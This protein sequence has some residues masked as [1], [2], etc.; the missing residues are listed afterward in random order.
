MPP[1]PPCPD[2][3]SGPYFSLAGNL[4]IDLEI[5]KQF[6]SDFEKKA[7]GKLRQHEGTCV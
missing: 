3:N 6:L 7:T 5:A 4:R 1:P 2:D